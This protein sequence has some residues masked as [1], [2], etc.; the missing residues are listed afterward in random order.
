MRFERLI[1]SINILLFEKSRLGF[2][3]KSTIINLFKK[4]FIDEKLKYN[5]KIFKN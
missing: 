3:K 5:Y 2:L 4:T 1:S